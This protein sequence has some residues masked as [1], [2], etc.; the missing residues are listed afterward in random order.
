MSLLFI[1]WLLIAIYFASFLHQLIYSMLA[2]KGLVKELRSQGIE[3]S[4]IK[5]ADYG[6]LVGK[7]AAETGE[8]YRQN[9]FNNFL[10]KIS[11]PC[12]IIGTIIVIFVNF[13]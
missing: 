13:S 8:K 9:R 3:I 1:G 4:K 2:F 12:L 11:I 10:R 7:R 6:R 5:E